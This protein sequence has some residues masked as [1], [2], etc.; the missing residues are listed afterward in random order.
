MFLGYATNLRIFDYNL[1]LQEIGDLSNVSQKNKWESFNLDL[2]N[3]PSLINSMVTTYTFDPLL[4][5]TSQTD[6]NGK[7]SYFEYDGLGRL[8]AL[9]D[10]QENLIKAVG[11]QYKVQQ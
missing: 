6:V 4:G 8:D 3:N 5:M 2:R 11:Y 7:N 1:F 10:Y 9:K